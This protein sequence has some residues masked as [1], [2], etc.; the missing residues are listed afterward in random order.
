[1]SDTDL[2]AQ[3]GQLPLLM[4][5]LTEIDLKPGFFCSRARGEGMPTLTL[6]QSSGKDMGEQRQVGHAIDYGAGEV[7]DC[8]LAPGQ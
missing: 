2:D 1:M 8:C 5:H 7:A 6:Q 4:S 3:S